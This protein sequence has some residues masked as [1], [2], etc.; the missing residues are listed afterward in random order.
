MITTLGKFFSRHHS[1][2]QF[3]KRQFGMLSTIRRNQ[4]P[5]LYKN[6]L[7]LKE[8]PIAA[9]LATDATAEKIEQVI[10]PVLLPPPAN[11]YALRFPPEDE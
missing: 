3:D 6:L 7:D 5:N 10:Q 9:T 11:E 2:P 1:V 8:K 4:F